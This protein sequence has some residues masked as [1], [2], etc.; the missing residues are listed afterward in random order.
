M[1]TTNVILVIES[2]M[3]KAHELQMNS[4]VWLTIGGIIA[5]LILIY[6]IITLVKPEKF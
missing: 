3:N 4:N 2:N 5:F 6:L 1:K